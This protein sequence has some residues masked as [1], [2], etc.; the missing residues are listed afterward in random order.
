MG[1]V[2]PKKFAAIIAGVIG[3]IAFT[4]ATGVWF[5]TRG[6]SGAIKSYAPAIFLI[7]VITPLLSAAAVFCVAILLR[8][9]HERAENIPI[10]LHELFTE[11]RT[12]I[13]P[14][15]AEKG[16]I[17]HFYAEP[18]ISKRPLGD[19]DMLREAL[20][21]LLSNAVRFTNTGMVKLHSVIKKT[22]KRDIT[23][24]FEVKDS[25]VGMT[26]EQIKKIRTAQKYGVKDMVEMMGGKLLVESAPGIGSKFSFDLTF[27]TIDISGGGDTIGKED[28]PDEF[29]KPSFEGEVLL[30]EDNDL[31]QQ[32]ICE[33]LALVGLKT[34]VAENGKI[35]VETVQN[36]IKEG[37]KL[38]DLILMDIHMPVMDGLEAAS[39]ILALHTG[40]P[41]VAIT[42][43]IMPT[44]LE[45]YRM[46]GM[47]DSVGKPF[48]SQ[49]LWHCLSK[50]C[51]PVSRH[52][53]ADTHYPQMSDELRKKI[54][55]HF[56][57][58]NRNT[59][60]EI[61]DALSADDIKTAHR[62]AHNLKSDAAQ[63][64]KI[65]LQQAAEEVEQQLK[66]GENRVTPQ[67]MAALEM[68]LN[69]ALAELTSLAQE[70]S[71]AEERI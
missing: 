43:N 6:T 7:C 14:K 20:E 62:L 66:D 4:N 48:T 50:Y 52:A 24:S 46:S 19:P 16:I 61:T 39:H 56:V 13:A 33:H 32:V 27:K 30:C 11:C 54:I 41:M 3:I 34:V 70:F 40:I 53:P 59:A 69:A 12:L 60:V 44:D 65:L 28:I 57:N 71:L 51:K 23:I 18:A 36:R 47:Y 67:Q 45:I 26:D 21:T 9:S 17:L 10:D 35:G 68:E 8:R 25:G 49:Q 22:R 15:A 2:Q 64:G 29:E 63:T 55:V 31:N 1:T 37:G 38:F 42:A 58:D 5:L